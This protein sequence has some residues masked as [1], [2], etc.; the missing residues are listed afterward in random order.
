MITHRRFD[1][2]GFMWNPPFSLVEMLDS[3]SW[4][5]HLMWSTLSHYHALRILY[6]KG[7]VESYSIKWSKLNLGQVIDKIRIFMSLSMEEALLRATR[8]KVTGI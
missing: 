3:F 4:E 7:D 8:D 2:A 1:Y 5:I 6:Q